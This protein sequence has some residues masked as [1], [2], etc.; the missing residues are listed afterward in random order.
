MQRAGLIDN[1]SA[2]ENHQ[3]LHPFNARIRHLCIKEYL[4]PL[5]EPPDWES[6]AVLSRL[7]QPGALAG[8]RLP[9]LDITSAQFQTKHWNMHET[10]T[11]QW[12][13]QHVRPPHP[14]LR[15]RLHVCCHT[16]QSFCKET[17]EASV[18]SLQK[19]LPQTKNW[20][21]LPFCCVSDLC[22]YHRLNL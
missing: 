15:T 14:P 3:G 13:I 19:V 22:K 1:A 8:G 12:Q 20:H 6:G 5:R 11:P 18:K 16:C 10:S 21:F 9:P 4:L 7:Q 2:G 17:K